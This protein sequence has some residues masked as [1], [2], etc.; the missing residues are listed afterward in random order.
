MAERD[1][2]SVRISPES[3]ERLDAL[4]ASMDRP[5][6]YLVNEAIDQYLAYH[7][8][9]ADRVREGLEAADRGDLV[10]HDEL[11]ASLRDRYRRARPASTKKPKTRR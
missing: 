4:A 2:F 5:R 9:K 1:T 3:R 10:E 6:S 7:S 8:W 11:F